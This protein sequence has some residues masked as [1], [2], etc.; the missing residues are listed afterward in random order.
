MK[1]FLLYISITLLTFL[2]SCGANEEAYISGSSG[3]ELKE[4]T[5]IVPETNLLTVERKLI[6]EGWVDFETENIDTTRKTILKAVD[7]FNGYVSNDVEYSNSYR[8]S[9]TIT[10]RVPSVSFDAFLQEATVGVEQFENKNI[11]VKDVT[12]EFLD[13]EVRLKTKKEIEQ[14]FIAL[15]QQTSSITEI[16]EVEQKLGELRS[17]IESIEGRLK[18]LSNQVSFSTL[19]LTFYK[20]VPSQTNFGKKF[21]NGIKNG[22]ENLIWFFVG[23]TNIWPFIVLTIGTIYGIRKYRRRKKKGH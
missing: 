16:L 14:R 12:E 7:K 23:L 22:W 18:F 13:I 17:E 15:L 3:E 5:E 8:V 20:S 19:T 10:V 11:D 2:V 4:V 6:K 21:Q 1:Q 9:N